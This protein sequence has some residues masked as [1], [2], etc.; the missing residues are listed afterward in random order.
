MKY[1][2]VMKY[3]PVHVWRTVLI[4]RIEMRK[5]IVPGA[6]DPIVQ[7]FVCHVV[8][9]RVIRFDSTAPEGDRCVDVHTWQSQ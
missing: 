5:C 4:L 2:R 6:S 8:N 9:M 3:E 7:Q 1:E